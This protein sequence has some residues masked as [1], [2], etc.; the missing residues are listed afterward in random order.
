MVYDSFNST[1]NPLALNPPPITTFPNPKQIRH[2]TAIRLSPLL[3]VLLG[4]MSARVT[5]FDLLLV[6]L[7]H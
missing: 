4:L 7:P 1:S 5:A 2:K 6:Y 3:Y